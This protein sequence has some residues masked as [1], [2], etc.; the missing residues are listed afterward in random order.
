MIKSPFNFNH[1]K[2]TQAINFFALKEDGIINR[3]KALKLLYLADRYH[4]RKYGRLIT[5][6]IYFAMDK[7]PVASGSKDIAEQC[8]FIGKSERDY[9]SRYLEVK[10]PHHV[11]SNKH[12]DNDVFSD[13]DIEALNFAW[14]RFG[15]LDQFQLVKLT[16]KYPEWSKHRNA[17]K[18]NTRIQMDLEDFF[19]DPVANVEKC[20]NLS[21]KAK[22]LR[23]EHLEEMAYLESVWR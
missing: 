2:A 17:L 12:P 20:F 23:R 19:D 13:S 9:A 10:K 7:G 18:L 3:M 14:E 4:L 21:N 15:G 6:D 5:N 11:K 8:D 22:D 16:H 1:R